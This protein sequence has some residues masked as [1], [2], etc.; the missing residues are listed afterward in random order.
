[1]KVAI[2][3]K[4]VRNF[5]LMGML[6]TP[7][8]NL[9]NSAWRN[10]A[11]RNN[12]P[13]SYQQN[14]QTFNPFVTCISTLIFGWLSDSIP[15]R[16]LYSGTCFFV[17]FIGV[18]FSFTFTSPVLFTIVLLLNTMANAAL[19][20][21]SLPHFMKVFGMKHYIEISGI[22]GLSGVIMGPICS[23]LAFFIE[24]NFRENL[25]TVYKYMF[26]S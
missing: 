21:I 19:I 20:S 5:F 2:K 9:I 22:I 17:S 16:Y 1:M 11:V 12:I 4:R 24:S 10:I 23:M 18:F 3:S 26:N 8:G 25:D 15:F 13:T 7:L 14:I 6:M